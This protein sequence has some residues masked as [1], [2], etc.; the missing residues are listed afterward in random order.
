MSEPIFKF[1]A[2]LLKHS[3][4][5]L[6]KF[7]GGSAG[8]INL[9]IDEK[10]VELTQA[11]QVSSA[12]I[13]LK[14]SVFDEYHGIDGTFV[15]SIDP[16]WIKAALSK[17]SKNQVVSMKLSDTQ[18]QIEWGRYKTTSATLPFDET[19]APVESGE[20]MSVPY[21]II[22]FVRRFS[23]VLRMKPYFSTRPLAATIGTIKKRPFLLV[24]DQYHGMI[25]VGADRVKR[26]IE[27]FSM[28]AAAVSAMA[29]DPK[30][31][32]SDQARLK[33][34]ITEGRV[35]LN[36]PNISYEIP[37]FEPSA[38]P[39]IEEIRQIIGM[40]RKGERSHDAM[41]NSLSMAEAASFSRRGEDSSQSFFLKYSDESV[42]CVY[43]SATVDSRCDVPAQ[44]KKWSGDITIDPNMFAEIVDQ[45]ANMNK[46]IFV[47][48]DMN[49]EDDV[50]TGEQMRLV[51]NKGNSVLLVAHG[52]AGVENYPSAYGFVIT[53]A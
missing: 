27:K 50:T 48:K 36:F 4:T 17:A 49:S 14:K 9:H 42:K 38:V 21:D 16:V 8:S 30:S 18:C 19:A 6:A 2:E 13:V 40:S 15:T 3:I 22:Q 7:L 25:I 29:F 11:S 53:G 33:L 43:S 24:N 39:S 46:S 52:L 23:T 47:R 32:E 10:R 31:N 41:M 35:I 44:K 37:A 28:D 20:Q 51:L 5:D 45:I 1:K 12:K 34:T 26:D